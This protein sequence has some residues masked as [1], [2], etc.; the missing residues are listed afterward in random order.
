MTGTHVIGEDYMT[1]SFTTCTL[2]QILSGDKIKKN[3][4]GGARSMYGGQERFI[5]GVGVDI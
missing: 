5:Q 4:M 1:R 2:Q 3:L